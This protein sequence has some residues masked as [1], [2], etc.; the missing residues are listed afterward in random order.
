MP[1][2]AIWLWP[3][4]R[5]ATA[6]P[7]M[8]RARST[9]FSLPESRI[10]ASLVAETENGTSCRLALRFCAVTMIS[11][12]APDG[13]S[14]GWALATRGPVSQPATT[15]DN[16][17]FLV[18]LARMILIATPSFAKCAAPQQSLLDPWQTYLLF[19]ILGGAPPHVT[20]AR[21]YTHSWVN[22]RH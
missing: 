5:S 8:L 9:I 11:S 3:G 22:G 10:C 4:P 17:R 13:C 21:R 15:T 20:M 2:I 19:F 16:P 14:A 1:R 18:K 7:A 6:N 12:N